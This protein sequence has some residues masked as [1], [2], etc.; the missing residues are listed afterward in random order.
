M[1][2][3]G[4]GEE[5][6]VYFCAPRLWRAQVSGIVREAQPL[7]VRPSVKRFLPSVIMRRVGARRTRHAW[8][9]AVGRC[10]GRSLPRPCGSP[11]PCFPLLAGHTLSV[12]W[13]GLCGLAFA[14]R[15]SVCGV[16]VCGGGGVRTRV[17]RRR[18]NWDRSHPP[19]HLPT[20]GIARSCLRP[21]V[22]FARPCTCMS[23]VPAT[24][25][26]GGP[27]GR[28]CAGRGRGHL[29]RVGDCGSAPLCHLPGNPPDG[30]VGM[31]V[32]CRRCSSLLP[33]APPRSLCAGAAP[34][35]ELEGAVVGCAGTA[36]RNVSAV[37]GVRGAPSSP[38]VYPASSLL[39]PTNA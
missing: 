8:P 28:R 16:C 39:C 34:C 37:C 20:H 10:M 17:W 11:A 32:P 25:P 23:P 31:W 29:G 2:G 1:A 26:W 30:P 33:A 5:G 7:V 9:T 6:G 12:W 3:E 4:R 21:P 35:R 15:G 36:L 14:L 18:G 13:G 22:G 38:A 24:R 19:A 27:G